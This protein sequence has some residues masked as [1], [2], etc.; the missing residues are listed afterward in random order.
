MSLQ[1]ISKDHLAT[2]LI[3]EAKIFGLVHLD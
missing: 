2:Q 1:K 3:G